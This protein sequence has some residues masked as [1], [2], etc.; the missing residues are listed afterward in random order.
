[1][2]MPRGLAEACACRA[3]VGRHARAIW[4]TELKK[5]GARPERRRSGFCGR[6]AAAWRQRRRNRCSGRRRRG[7]VERRVAER[8]ADGMGG[9]GEA[10][11]GEAF[12]A[13]AGEVR[14]AVA[15]ALGVGLRAA[16]RW[17]LGCVA[18]CV[19][20]RAEL[21]EQDKHDKQQPR[22]HQ[23]QCHAAVTQDGGEG[24]WP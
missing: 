24:Q 9:K 10:A 6:G 22:G 14:T 2:G 4:K 7:E 19:D 11:E 21:R 15:V 5:A 17:R 8:H 12:G 3:G 20:M 16:V 23:A 18:D 13:E 1:M